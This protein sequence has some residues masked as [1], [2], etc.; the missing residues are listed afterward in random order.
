MYHLW[1]WNLL[2]ILQLTSLIKWKL[3]LLKEW[4][5]SYTMVGNTLLFVRLRT[6]RRKK[7]FFHDN[8]ISKLPSTKGSINALV[9]WSQDHIKVF[10][11]AFF[12]S[13]D[14]S[15]ICISNMMS[16]LFSSVVIVIVI[17]I[18]EE[19]RTRI[20]IIYLNSQPTML[21]NQHYMLLP[22]VFIL[23]FARL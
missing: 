5:G 22:L 7:I 1:T 15:E 8:P 11:V 16:A 12:Y 23:K 20:L 6:S 10:R 18:V 9:L 14:I 13:R 2:V 19:K 17:V 3:H 4:N 21:S